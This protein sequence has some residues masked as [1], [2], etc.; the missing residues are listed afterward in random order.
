MSA[1]LTPPQQIDFKGTISVD[2]SK[3]SPEVQAK[4]FQAAGLQISSEE[5]TGDHQMVPHE[6]VTE[7]E[8]TDE[9]GVPVKQK[10]AMI[11]PAGKLR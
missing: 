7:K 1:K 6:V 11:N 10:V 8:G 4:V 5:A 9:Q 3:Y 2:P